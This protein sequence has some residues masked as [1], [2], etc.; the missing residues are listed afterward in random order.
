MKKNEIEQLIQHGLFPYDQEAKITCIETPI[1]FIILKG[2][3]AYKIKKDIKLSFLDFSTLKK[4]KE[5]CY[6]ELRLNM[7]LA[8]EIY[9]DVL[10]I[11]KKG[12][13][14]EIKKRAAVPHDYAVRM[15][16]IDTSLQLD[17]QLKKNRVDKKHI[18]KIAAQIAAFHLKEKVIKPDYDPFFLSREFADIR[19]F[20]PTIKKIVGMD[21]FNL[22]E[23]SIQLSDAVVLLLQDFIKVRVQNGFFK[24]CHGDLHSK[25][26]FMTSPPIIFDCIE[27]KKEFREID[28]LNEIAFLC[29]DL[30]CSGHKKLSN[31]FLTTYLNKTNYDFGKN[32]K[33]LF[34]YFKAYRACIRAKVA[35]IGLSQNNTDKKL[36]SEVKKYS[37]AMANYLIGIVEEI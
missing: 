8:K 26:I 28:V 16:R 10:P 36:I 20:Q 5:Y 3:Y 19:S 17:L 4:R 7:R 22:I 34:N 15:K 25:N 12:K 6:E 31:A 14:W 37:E 24:D 27:F 11:V 30:E 32:E 2:K 1:S 35:A 23:Q 18:Q 21:H 29:M 9:L 33:L 13:Q